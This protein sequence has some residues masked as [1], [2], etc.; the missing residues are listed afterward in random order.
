MK[1]RKVKIDD[2]KE[3]Q[4]LRIDTL[5]KINSCHYNK[6]Q[7]RELVNLNKIKEVIKKINERDMFCLIEDKQIKGVIDLY[8]NNIGGLYIKH[9]EINKG[10]GTKLLKFIEKYVKKK[11]INKLILYPTKFA[12]RFYIKH[13]Y[14]FNNKIKQY[15]LNKIRFRYKIM[16]KKL[17]KTGGKA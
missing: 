11:G 8:H 6:D 12:E 10:Y 1:I 5:K 3:I 17:N 9:T 14:R 4:K 7:L 15:S 13:G 16:E 2:A